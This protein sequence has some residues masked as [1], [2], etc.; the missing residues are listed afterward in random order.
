MRAW[1]HGPLDG[2]L[3]VGNDGTISMTVPSVDA[4]GYAEVRATFPRQWI[5]AASAHSPV[6][7]T[8]TRLDTVLAE[9]E[10]LAN[11][12]NADRIKSLLFIV[13]CLIVSAAVIVWALV[14]FFR[15]GREYK[16][17]FSDTYWRDVP[18]R[19]IHPRSSDA[20]G[21]GT[22]KATRIS[23]PRSC[24]FPASAPFE[25]MREATNNRSRSAARAR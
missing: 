18:E 15:H 2:T 8:G 4:G 12:A 20:F 10:R 14:I 11:Q 23:R 17:E 16:P 5:S 6:F 25:S 7:H 3:T 13:V 21:A 22:A 24:T 19:G 1:A 9:E